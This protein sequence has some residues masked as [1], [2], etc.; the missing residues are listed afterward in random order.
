[1][2][3]GISIM[4]EQPEQEAANDNEAIEELEAEAPLPPEVTEEE[5]AET[6]FRGVGEAIPSENVSSEWKE[7]VSRNTGGGEKL[8]ELH[9]RMATG[10]DP[11]GGDTDADA[12]QAKVMGEEAVGGLAPT[13]EQ[14]VT[15]DLQEATG[16]ET[17]EREIVHTEEKLE[18]RDQHRWQ[19][20]P[21]SSEDYE[22]RP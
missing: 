9:T 22:E 16:I 13:P 3:Q 7:L 4:A 20:D 11:T 14:D 12:Y 6:G 2:Q 5:A 10:S 8:E 19:L 17:T 1:M 21:E 15:E 18:W